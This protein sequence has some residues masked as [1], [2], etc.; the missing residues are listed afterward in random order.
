MLKQ[1]AIL[2]C[3]LVCKLCHP[4]KQLAQLERVLGLVA[5]S[6]AA[7]EAML[8]E[9]RVLVQ[10]GRLDGAEL[11]GLENG[12]AMARRL[13]AARQLDHDGTLEW[14]TVSL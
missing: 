9:L 10:R 2:M 8:A 13:Q 11:H 12:L 7:T 14:A 6:I 3:N 5:E 4:L 1:R